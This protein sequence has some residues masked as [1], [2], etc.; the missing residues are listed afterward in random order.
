M[1]SGGFGGGV[2]YVADLLVGKDKPGLR[3][4]TQLGLAVL[5]GGGFGMP[6][7]GAGVAGAYAYNLIDNLKSGLSEMEDTKYAD[8]DAL[9][10]YPDALDEEG[11]PMFLAEDGNFYY[12][13]EFE[14][15]ED[16]EYYLAEDMQARLYPGYVN[17]VV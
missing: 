8:E 16:G 9:D 14:L 17:P 2:A 5:I 15:S 6:Q 12:L 3:A 4:V 11:N 7:T 1:L 10:Q 13:E